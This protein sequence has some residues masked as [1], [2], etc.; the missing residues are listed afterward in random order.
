MNKEIF[1]YLEW[2]SVGLNLLFV[3][4]IIREK[5][6]GWIFGIIGSFI[7]IALFISVK[8]YSEAV[9]Y[10]Y[11]VAMGYYGWNTWKTNTAESLP[12]SEKNLVY[13]LQLIL[14]CLVLSFGLGAFFSASTDA[15]RP[16]ADAFSSIF[17]FLATYL[18]A[19]KILSAWLYWIFLNAFSVWL[20]HERGLAVYA[21][22]MILYTILSIVGYVRWKKNFDQAIIG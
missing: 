16:Y 4:Y 13:H 11:Y 12:I 2:I 6:M 18:E 15:Q 21:G 9:L 8:L 10:S 17:S 3:F 22:L 7:S 5:R 20:Y 14:A 19:R 1:S